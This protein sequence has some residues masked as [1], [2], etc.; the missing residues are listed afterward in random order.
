MVA[1]ADDLSVQD[2]TIQELTW[3]YANTTN[4]VDGVLTS[5]N[6]KITFTTE[7]SPITS[8]YVDFSLKSSTSTGTAVFLST[9][10][11]SYDG[12]DGMTVNIREGALVTKN[13]SGYNDYSLAYNAEDEYRF[14]L[15]GVNQK[16][17]LVNK[18]NGSYTVMDLTSMVE[19]TNNFSVWTNGGSE[20]VAFLGASAVTGNSWS[21]S[22]FRTAVQATALVPEPATASLSL[23]ALGALA[24]RRRRA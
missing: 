24:L 9:A 3:A 8:W 5:G 19:L 17:Y 23:L 1:Q 18:S 16:M 6:S 20:K 10:R 7:L 14:A 4:V 21:E 11:S 2:I 15:D 13:G 12:A 22:E